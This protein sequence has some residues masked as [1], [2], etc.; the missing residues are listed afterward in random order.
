MG[1]YNQLGGSPTFQDYLQNFD[2]EFSVAHLKLSAGQPGGHAIT[3]PPENYVINITFDINI[4]SQIPPLD[5]AGTMI[6]EMIHAEIFRKMMIAAQTGSLQPED[7]TVAQQTAYVQNLQ[8]N[9]PGI[10]DYYISRYHPN[11]DHQMMAQHYREIIKNA[12]R[13][14]DPF[15]PEEVYEA[16]AWV[17]LMGEGDPSPTTGLPP[18]PTVA[19]S[20]DSQAQRLQ[21]LNTYNNFKNSNPRCQ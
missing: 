12:L 7:M 17:G 3:Y 4:L 16:I 19:W 14:F 20:H 21:I 1:V 13:E 18:Y 11:W 15:Q 6:H 8:N 5:V 9:F 10:Y 2:G